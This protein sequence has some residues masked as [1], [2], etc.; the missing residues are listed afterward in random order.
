M[1][2]LIRF[3]LILPCSWEADSESAVS[4]NSTTRASVMLG[5]FP[6]RRDSNPHPSAAR[7]GHAPLS[8]CRFRHEE[9]I[10]LYNHKARLRQPLPSDSH[11]APAQTR[12]ETPLTGSSPSDC[13]VCQ[14]HHEG[15]FR[16][17]C[18]KLSSSLCCSQ[19]SLLLIRKNAA[20]ALF[21]LDD[22][23]I[24]TYRPL[25]SGFFIPCVSERTI[26]CCYM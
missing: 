17:F 13:R 26:F 3:E 19:G 7:S 14:F 2:P 22:D 16:H 5:M 1:V 6:P 18:L 20:I 9:E 21:G 24:Q 8:V 25:V 12:T 10:P 4:A 23:G 15:E 11:G